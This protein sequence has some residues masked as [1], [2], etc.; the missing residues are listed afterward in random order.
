VV[1]SENYE[2]R[3][4][5][6]SIPVFVEVTQ[7]LRSPRRVPVRITVIRQVLFDHPVRQ[8]CHTSPITHDPH[9]L[10]ALYRADQSKCNT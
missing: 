8:W 3:P 9:A 7:N 6:K 10:H 1:D 4:T 5:L 2:S